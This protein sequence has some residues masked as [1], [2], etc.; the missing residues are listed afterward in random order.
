M[1]ASPGPQADSAAPDAD[2]AG[3]ESTCTCT[4]CRPDLK[5]RLPLIV[6]ILLLVVGLAAAPFLALVVTALL[7]VLLDLDDW[8]MYWVLAVAAILLGTV[9]LLPFAWAHQGGTRSDY[10]VALPVRVLVVVSASVL[11]LAVTITIGVWLH[12]AG[13][14]DFP[15][16]VV[17][18][19]ALPVLLSIAIG[20][21]G[22]IVPPA[23]P[24]VATGPRPG[25]PLLADDVFE[26]T[27]R[28]VVTLIRRDEHEGGLPPDAS[29]RFGEWSL[30]FDLGDD[31]W[32]ECDVVDTGGDR[33]YVDSIREIDVVDDWD[34]EPV[35]GLGD[36]AY[37]YTDQD[38]DT[39]HVSAFVDERWSIE[40]QG[41]G[42]FHRADTLV[43]LAQATIDRLR[44]DGR[45][46]RREPL[47]GPARPQ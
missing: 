35:P 29:Q 13:W 44:R 20:V 43:C 30:Q 7:D 41:S 42:H 47:V 24:R 33:E 12:Q 8:A 18:C 9:C 32:V 39:V 17:V 14:R 19:V 36:E 21:A 5:R 4:W 26:V 1:E 16:V 3:Q 40:M 46:S 34:S 22:N 27:R 2:A 38:G 28:Q 6:R 25:D 37:A 31:R 45:L 10:P 15:I 11:P 23:E